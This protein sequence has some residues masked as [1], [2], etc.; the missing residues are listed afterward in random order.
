MKRAWPALL[1]SLLGYAAI[2]GAVFRSGL[3]AR[4]TSP[5][6]TTSQLEVKLNNEIARK[7]EGPQILSVG[8]SR[9]ALVPRI[10]NK[11]TAETGF[12]VGSI[13]LAGTTPRVWYYMLRD[14]DP[15]ANRY[16][17]VV[18][19]MD[20]FDDA[21]TVEDYSLR[22]SDL[23]YLLHRLRWSD[24]PEFV[25][26]YKLRPFQQRAARGL[27]FKGSVYQRDFQQFLLDP[28]ARIYIA[29]LTY[30]DSHIWHYDY[31]EADQR[32][33]DTPPAPIQQPQDIGRYGDYLKYWLT[34]IADR[35]RDSPTKLVF[36]RLPRTPWP[37]SAAPPTKADSSVRT[38]AQRPNVVLI[39]PDMFDFLQRPEYFK[40]PLH[41]N[42]TGL[43]LFTEKLAR[44]L[45]K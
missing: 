20:T 9:M 33:P 37:G 18:I 34:R 35:Y 5:E 39:A 4:Y 28:Q 2:E 40:D 6:S 41:L 32:V 17:A 16:R 30:R 14:I 12:T 13:A 44:E 21:E 27:I 22:E 8:D 42:Q 3:Y 24:F 7:K 45:A 15:D 23:N 38:L 43:N 31:I 11:L 29:D 36:V 10:A 26:S 19:G 25:R 1:A